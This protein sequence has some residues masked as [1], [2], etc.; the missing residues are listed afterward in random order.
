MVCMLGASVFATPAL[1]KARHC[2]RIRVP[3]MAI[4]GHVP[5]AAIRVLRGADTCVYARA[6][7]AAAYKAEN[8]KN[9]TGGS[10]PFADDHWVEGWL[11]QPVGADG[12]A[13]R[14]RKRTRVIAG[15]LI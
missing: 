14:C 12:A 9:Y 6:L 5:N 2:E 8:P 3:V 11:C 1:A 10:D 13:L 15:S 7:I 4:N